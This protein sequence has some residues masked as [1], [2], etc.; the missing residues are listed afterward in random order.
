M[1]QLVEL[2]KNKDAFTEAGADVIAVFREEKQGEAGLKKIA[3]KTETTFNLA[4]DNGKKQTGRYSTGR[5]EF[6]GYVIN[7]KGVIANVFKGDL[8]NRAKAA[9]LIAAVKAT[10]EPAEGSGSKDSDA[11][12]TETKGATSEGSGAKSSEATGSS[13][14][15]S[16]AEGSAK[17]SSGSANK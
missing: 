13:A 15:E 2:G 17:K 7:A 5:R 9:E 16:A 1:T 8:R 4:L 3:A 11:K 6:T 10:S 12:A 14:K